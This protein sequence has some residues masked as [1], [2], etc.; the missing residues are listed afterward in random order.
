MK[1]WIATLG[2]GAAL[3]V[4]APNAHA[5]PIITGGLVNVTVT[6]VANNVL[7]NVNVSL[8]VALNLAANVC[9]VAVNVLASQIG[10][11]PVS[12]TSAT[13]GQTVTIAKLL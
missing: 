9:G 2:L 8:G 6:D 5:Q 12:C 1:K 11:G 4:A 10:S 7:Q 13:N 3:A